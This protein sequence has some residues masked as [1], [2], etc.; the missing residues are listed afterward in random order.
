MTQSEVE[1]LLPVITPF[2]VPAAIDTLYAIAYAQFGLDAPQGVGS[3]MENEAVTYYIASLLSSGAG[4]SG[5]ESEKIDDYSITF[6]DGGQ[7]QG[8]L[9]KY[10]MIVD[11]CNYYAT[12]ADI[13]TGQTRDDTLDNL[14]LDAA[15]MVTADDGEGE[16]L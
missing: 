1:A 14:D 4:T 11:K 6:S 15:G 5:V 7:T 8:Y 3:S 16:Y 13:S 2:P 9:D 12:T 10:Q